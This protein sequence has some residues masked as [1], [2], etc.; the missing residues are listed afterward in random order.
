MGELKVFR[1]KKSGYLIYV[2]SDGNEEMEMMILT[3]AR[4]T[5]EIEDEKPPSYV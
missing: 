2:A 5:I 4:V 1:P 3:P